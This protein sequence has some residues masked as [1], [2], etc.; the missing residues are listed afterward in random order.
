MTNVA[1]LVPGIMGSELKLDGEVVWPGPLV[2]LVGH[3]RKFEQLTSDRIRATDVIRSVSISEQYA[4]IIRDL[5]SCGFEEGSERP[6]LVAFAY[7]WRIDN[8]TNA[9]A[10]A[11]KL[12]WVVAVHGGDAEISLIGHSMGGLISRYF[13]ES[14]QFDTRS[15]WKAVR[16]LS[17]LGT[18]HRGSP[19][20]LTAAL[21]ME[22]R[23]FLSAEQVRDLGSMPAFPSLY[24]LLPPRGEPFAWSRRAE[25]AY[26]A[27]DIYDNSI[28][29]TLGL[30]AENLSAAAEFHRGL[31]LARRPQHVRYFFFVGTRQKTISHVFVNL[32]ANPPA[33][34]RVEAD[35]AGD[36]TV[37]I[38]SASITGIQGRPVGGEHGTIYRNDDLRW[39]LGIL[40]GKEIVLAPDRARVEIA[41]R[42]R[43]VHP[44]DMVNMAVTWAVPC[45]AVG[46]R[47]QIEKRTDGDGE[48]APSFESIGDPVSLNYRGGGL[49]KLN[50]VVQA[51]AYPGLYRVAFYP[52]EANEAAATDELFVQAEG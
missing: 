50:L 17:T 35:D 48:G 23:L 34:L 25:D 15:G 41:L 44:D 10:L 14:G 20:A 51:P 33:V 2:S 7:D 13:L 49:E 31:D 37:P 19:L 32:A 29:K 9:A 36:G 16:T 22:K 1:V 12:D 42:E 24:Q 52:A 26:R 39:T 47:I 46:A 38:W 5:E 40:L 27:V 3:Y 8:R 30:V 45:D 11:D 4:A 18:P 6:T 28:A 43:V 21:G